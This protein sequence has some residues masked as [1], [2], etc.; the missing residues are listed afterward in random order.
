MISIAAFLQLI[1]VKKSFSYSVSFCF[2]F[3]VI[4]LANMEHME[5][6]F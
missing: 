6:M 3:V 4:S 1:V 5:Q 2:H